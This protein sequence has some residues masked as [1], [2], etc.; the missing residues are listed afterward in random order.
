MDTRRRPG[1]QLAA[2][3]DWLELVP[4]TGGRRVGNVVIDPHGASSR[5]KMNCLEALKTSC[6]LVR[7]AAGADGLEE[8]VDTAFLLA[9][10]WPE[11]TK[12][13]TSIFTHDRLREKLETAARA[14]PDRVFSPHVEFSELARVPDA[15]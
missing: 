5:P 9:K 1:S 13:L 7:S 4:D 8:D 6:P 10:D 12:H 14:F 11:F 2:L 3:V 15:Q